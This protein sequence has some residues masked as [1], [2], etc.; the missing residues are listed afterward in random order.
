V[1]LTPKLDVSYRAKVEVIHS[2]NVVAPAA[3]AQ[4][5]G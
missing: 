3:G 1:T 5:S 4:P 2:K